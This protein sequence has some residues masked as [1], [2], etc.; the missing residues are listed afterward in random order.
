MGIDCV[1]VTVEVDIHKGQTSFTV[2]GLPDPSIKE[3]K[4]RLYSALKNS[5]FSYPFNF[6]I[7]INL[8][9]ADTHKEGAIYDLPMAMGMIALSN[10]IAMASDD[11]LIAGE[12]GLDGLVRH[13][14]GVLSLALFAKEK[15]LV[16]MFVPEVDAAEAALVSGITIYPVKSLAQLV[17]HFTGVELIAP[18]IP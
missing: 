15:G 6:R 8:A 14:P 12:L 18:Y 7:V 10:E 16:R 3:S 17:K 13:I 2:V 4:D 5:G 1:P 11:T 9:P